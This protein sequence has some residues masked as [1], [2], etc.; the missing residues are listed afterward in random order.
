[1]CIRDRAKV[2]ELAIGEIQISSDCTT[3]DIHAESAQR[4][5]EIM[6][7]REF[8]GNKLTANLENR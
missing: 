3:V 6:E 4:V 5:L 2:K 7:R 1:M 8:N